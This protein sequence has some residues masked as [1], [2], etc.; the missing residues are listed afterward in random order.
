VTIREI[1]CRRPYS[2]RSRPRTRG[3]PIRT[4][5][6]PLRGAVYFEKL[7]KSVQPEQQNRDLERGPDRVRAITNKAVPVRGFNRESNPRFRSTHLLRKCL[8]R[9]S[10]TRFSRPLAGPGTHEFLG[11][12]RL[13]ILR[14][15]RRE[16]TPNGACTADPG[17]IHG[18]KAP[19]RA[20]RWMDALLR[21]EGDQDPSVLPF[22]LQVVVDIQ[23]PSGVRAHVIRALRYQHAAPS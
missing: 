15:G 6:D 14:S 23:K 10:R 2:A 1:A 12:Q 13:L 9:E 18:S 20:S 17:G 7:N 8:R 4:R 19:V 21:I 5:R 3:Q 22:K 11:M 16:R